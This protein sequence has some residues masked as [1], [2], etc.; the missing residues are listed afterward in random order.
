MNKIEP[1]FQYFRLSFFFIQNFL[2][3]HVYEFFI[4]LQQTMSPKLW[5]KATICSLFN[6]SII[7]TKLNWAVVLPLVSGGVTH[8]AVV[9]LQLN[10]S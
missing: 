5:L 8:M 1:I 6:G 10:L 7:W 9:K 4:A 3:I 2:Q